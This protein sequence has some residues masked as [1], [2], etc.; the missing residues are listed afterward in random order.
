MSDIRLLQLSNYV[1]PKLEE[2]KT[3][4]WVLNGKNNNFYQY[5][6]D[7]FNGSPTNSAIITSY[8]DLIYGNGLMARNKN[9]PSWIN[10]LTILNPKELRKIISDFELFGEASFQVIKTKDGKDINSIYHIPKQLVVP[11]LENED[12]DIEGYFYCKDWKDT[13][14]YKPE[15]FPSFGTSNESIEIY[16][17]KPY[18]AG[19]NYFSDPDYLSALP[20]CEME[21]ELANFYIN[22]IKKGLSA[23]YVINIP[24]G[25][26]LTPEQKDE[27]ED[28]IKKKLTGSPNAMNFVISFNGRD[29]EITII[30]FPVNDA[31]HKQWE[32]LT[33][34]SR[35]QIMTAHRVVSPKLFGIM[36]EGGLGNNANELDEAEGQLMKR[37][38]SPKQRIL[39]E[40]IEEVLV[41]YGINLDLYFRPL[42]EKEA[43]VQMNNHNHELEDFLNSGESIDL[44]AWEVVDVEKWT[45]KSIHIKEIDLQFASVPDNLPLAPSDI[46]NEY[47]KVRFEYAGSLNPERD[48][49]KKMISAGK[50]FRLEDID[51]ASTMAVNPGWGPKGASTYYDILKYK[52]GGDCHHF[53]QRKVYLKKDNKNITVERAQ[54]VIRDLKG[55]GISTKIPESP[56]PLS[57]KKPTDMPYNGFL[58]TNKRFQ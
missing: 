13:N 54:K 29:A 36:S 26:T 19:K 52:G 31:Q 41:F 8:I 46:D 39:L 49:C 22:S 10:F 57:T 34:E 28:K 23:G 42:T 21:E 16:C 14:K 25:G 11:A 3:K 58:P 2:N 50:V 55:L 1:R 43:S 17:I 15:Y 45:D 7:R 51:K 44:E 18:K 37:V 56:E 48:F 53:W 12:G 47:F 33:G 30:P 40:A 24:D 27:L 32:Y 5:V 4:N 6:I 38:I 20:Y 35:Q 9:M